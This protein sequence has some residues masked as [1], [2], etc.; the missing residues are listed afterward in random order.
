MRSSKQRFCLTLAV[1]C[2]CL[3]ACIFADEVTDGLQ[4]GQKLLQHKEFQKAAAEFH[5]II[6]K[7]QG[8]LE[9]H[10]RHADVWENFGRALQGLGK[11]EL[12]IKA[13]KR[14]KAIRAERARAIDEQKT[15][16]PPEPE[17]VSTQADSQPTTS[18]GVGQ[19]PEKSC[20]QQNLISLEL[21]KFLRLF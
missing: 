5:Q 10:P 9:K 8:N 18:A 1:F 17:P 4:A 21:R 3:P 19:K 7:Q 6:M 13:I 2:F 14:A 11:K 20:T 16:V 12:A 15:V